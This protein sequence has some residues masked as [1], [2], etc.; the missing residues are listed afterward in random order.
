MPAEYVISLHSP[1]RGAKRVD[2]AAPLP[3]LP[4]PLPPAVKPLPAPPPPLTNLLDTEIGKRLQEDR[5]SIE[6]TLAALS[7]AVNRLTEQRRLDRAEMQHAAV[8]LAVT[9]ATRLIH[10]RIQQDTFAVE[11]LVRDLLDQFSG[12]PVTVHLNP[13]DLALLKKR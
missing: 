7:A 8:E 11:N 9:L 12:G 4:A 1:L 10:D 5:A 3:P 2:P 13:E 6:R